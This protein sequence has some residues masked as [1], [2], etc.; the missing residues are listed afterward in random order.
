MRTVAALLSY[1]FWLSAGNHAVQTD[2]KCG[3]PQVVKPMFQ[4][5]RVVGGT[6]AKY[7]SHPWLWVTGKLVPISSSQGARSRVH[8]GQVSVQNR[9]FH[10]CGGAILTDS[11]ILT[12][13]HCFPFVSKDF[14]SCLRVLV[15]EF[16]LRADD[17][18]EQ[19]FTVKSVSVHEKYNQAFPMNYD[20]ALVEL[21]HHIRMGARVRPICLPLPDL[22]IP[23][24]TNCVVAGWGKTR[25]SLYFFDHSALQKYW[26]PLK[27][28]NIFIFF[29]NRCILGGFY[30]IVKY[31]TVQNCKMKGK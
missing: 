31:K 16:D 15:G 18:D 5:L 25:E 11:W 27:F 9:G 20:I 10:F 30:V 3:T 17:E 24:W 4:F 28:F 13:A 23:P 21:D 19:A 29:N 26:N 6:Q 12:A 22:Q 14:L 8:P 2:Q 1:C 7:G